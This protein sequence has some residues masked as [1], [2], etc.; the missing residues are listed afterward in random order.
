MKCFGFGFIV[1]LIIRF[2]ACCAFARCFATELSTIMI[3]ISFQE[4]LRNGGTIILTSFQPTK[5]SFSII[6]A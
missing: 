5:C 2:Q 3:G 6:A 4:F 1:C